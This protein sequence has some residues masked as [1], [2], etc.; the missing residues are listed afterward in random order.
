MSYINMKDEWKLLLGWLIF[1]SLLLLSECAPAPNTTIPSTYE[2]TEPLGTKHKYRK[3]PLIG[4]SYYCII[5][6]APEVIYELGG[7]KRVRRWSGHS[8]R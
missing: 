1:V 2:L 6:E 4:K 3:K 7:T 5:H 8:W